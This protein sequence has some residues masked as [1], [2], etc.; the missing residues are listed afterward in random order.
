MFSLTRAAT[1]AAAFVTMAASAAFA[2]PS[3]A[4]DVEAAPIT[5]R[6]IDHASA[7]LDGSALATNSQGPARLAHDVDFS[8][9]VATHAVAAVAATGLGSVEMGEERQLE[10]GR[11]SGRESVG[12]EG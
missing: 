5:S 3:M 4:W 11:A 7:D 12:Q 10:I 2:D 1:Y 8:T 9:P 6:Y